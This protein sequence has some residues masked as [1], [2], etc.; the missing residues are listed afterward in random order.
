MER[1]GGEDSEEWNGEKKD[2]W[3]PERKEKEIWKR[4]KHTSLGLY[5][6]VG[7][8]EPDKTRTIRGD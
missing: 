8:P 4:K 5:N 1:K 6:T 3:A 2:G 7:E